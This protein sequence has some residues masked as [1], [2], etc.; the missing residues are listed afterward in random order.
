MKIE[1]CNLEGVYIITPRIFKDDR[2]YFFESF[3]QKKFN[4]LTGVSVQFVQDNQSKSHSGVVRGMHM[5]TPP[6]AQAKLIRVLNG[7]ILDVVVD[8]RKNSPTYGEHFKIELSSENFKQLFIPQ[9]FAHGFRTLSDETTIVYKC[10]DF[11][12]PEHEDC[13]IWNDKDLNI[14]WGI[15]NPNCFR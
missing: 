6:K 3:N 4:E 14:D 8:V 10:S 2:G 15:E 11:Y 12:S 1:T 5:Q 7:S 13:I 9:G